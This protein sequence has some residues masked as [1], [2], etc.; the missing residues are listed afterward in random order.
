MKFD[1]IVVGSGAGGGIAAC[2]LAEA[3][4]KVLVLE[5]GRE[6]GF[7]D[8][9]R[10]HLR[11]H[12][13][14]KYGHGTGPEID[15]NPRL[16]NGR[17]VRPHEGGYQ[18]NASCV[19]GGTLV[20][21][22]QA[23]RFH[24]LDFRMATTY[25][26]PDGSSL[27]DW[28][29]QY[30]DLERYYERAEWEI[31]VA[32]G[33]PAPQMPLRRPYPMPAFPHTTKAKK[34]KAGCDKLGWTY[35]TPPLLINS[36]DHAGRRACTHCQHCVGFACPVDAKNG[37]QNTVIPRALVSG[38]CVLES[39]AYV[40]RLLKSRGGKVTGVSYVNERGE[41]CSASSEVVV[42]A[43]GAIETARL[44]LNSRL[45]GPMVG[46]SLQGH[47]YAIVAGIM[48]DPIWDGDGPGV[49][50]ST[51]EF[52]HGNPGIIGGG[53]MADDFI[54]LPVGYAMNFRPSDIP[55]W[56]QA[57]KDW[58][59]ETYRRFM[60]VGGPIHEIPNADCR[61]NVSTRVRD[62]WGVP[63]ASLSGTTH[64]ET[65]R[66]TKFMLERATEWLKASGAERTYHGEPGLHLSAGQHQAGTCRMGTDPA[67]SVVDADCRVHGHD[68][69]FIADSSVH[70]TNGGF[71]P[72]L[73]IM[74]LSFRTTD[75]LVKSW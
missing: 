7:A 34:L 43:C 45:G 36:V 4:K 13:F 46:T 15:G 47:Y 42:L 38:N 55:S 66:T 1:A 70:V 10:D 57:H 54:T 30:E 32:G 69:L 74:A 11:N 53:M 56:G 17:Q 75:R 20:Y 23:W 44:M 49:S 59:R 52:N 14:A 2:L 3:G 72:V 16:F 39:K 9:P 67:T 62:R 18:N 35:Q 71:N 60:Q 63:V 6:L 33:E 64:P 24:P 21:G 19:G 8:V 41:R 48:R 28:P 73:T 40:T 29:I 26:V 25:G 31:G 50:I 61:V 12:R 68:N 22:A 51:L 37:T 5:K 58:M 65:V 27:A